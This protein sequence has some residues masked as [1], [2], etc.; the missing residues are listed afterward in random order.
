MSIA[1]GEGLSIEQAA[2]ELKRKTNKDKVRQ[3]RKKVLKE[4]GALKLPTTFFYAN[5]RTA[6]VLVATDSVRELKIPYMTINNAIV[7]NGNGTPEATIGIK[8]RVKTMPFYYS[9]SSKIVKGTRRKPGGKNKV[10]YSKYS[11]VWRSIAVPADA[12]VADLINNVTKWGAKPEMIR[13][14][15]SQIVTRDA[16]KNIAL[17]K[18]KAKNI[19]EGAR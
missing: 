3:Q 4:G 10:A 7:I 14:G 9:F 19:L 15:S 11:R 12:T 6:Y 8:K 13:I 18:P 17:F 5:G 16:L 2:S 1:T